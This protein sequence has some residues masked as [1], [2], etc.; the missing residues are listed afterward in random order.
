M[1][2]Q[3]LWDQY[4]LFSKWLHKKN[5][6]PKALL[7]LI[8]CCA[9][10]RQAWL[11]ALRSLF[12]L[13]FT[14]WTLSINLQSIFFLPLTHF[15]YLFIILFCIIYSWHLA[16]V[17]SKFVE[18]ISLFNLSKRNDVTQWVHILALTL[19]VRQTQIWRNSRLVR[20][21]SCN[22]T[23]SGV[24]WPEFDPCDLHGEEK[25]WLYHKLSSSLHMRLLIFMCTTSINT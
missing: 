25:D 4:H 11:T 23:H 9:R 14:F 2:G 10:P 18:W 7:Q 15:P 22:E 20:W 6:E 17:H 5:E 21:L 12:T 24:W 3:D 19:H 8:I 13:F 1:P 16:W